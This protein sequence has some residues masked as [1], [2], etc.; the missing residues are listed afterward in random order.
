MIREPKFMY[1]CFTCGGEFQFGPHVYD[2]RHIAAYDMTFCMGCY[3]GNWDGWAPRY[4]PRILAHLKDKGLEAP[5][6]N[7]GGYLPRHPD[8]G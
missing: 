8:L 2:G 1:R 7:E 4:E 5:A 6:R 3:G